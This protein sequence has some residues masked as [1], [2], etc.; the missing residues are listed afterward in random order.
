MS[1]QWVFIEPN[2]VWM[3]RDS[4]PFDAQQNF[5]ARSVFPPYPM[6]IQGVIRTYFLES[7]GADWQRF[8]EGKERAE[9]HAIAGYSD[10]SGSM[11]IEGP[12]VARMVKGKPERLYPAPLDLLYNQKDYLLLQPAALPAGVVLDQP[13]AGWKPLLADATQENYKEAGG[14]LSE[15]QMG[16]YLQGKKPTGAP[17][18]D[19]YETEERVGLKLNAKRRAAEQGYLY[20]AQFLR[21]Y[22]GVG[23]LVG[24]SEK[25]FADRGV[26]GIGGE[27]RSGRYSMVTYQQRANAGKGRIK[28][29]LQ[30][31]AYFAQGWQPAGGDWSPFISGRL[32]SAAIGKPISISGWNI[33][34]R[35]PKALRHYVPAGSVF[36]FE[37]A[38]L[39]GL[40]FTET[41]AAEPGLNFG[42][43]GFGA[44]VS[45]TW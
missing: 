28:V 8:A 34:R 19:L 32:V 23:L 15:E 41:P 10:R 3:F 25:I 2:D 4:R 37:D 27:A 30:T 22:D 24:V 5:V 36:Y 7:R 6:T 12:F 35:E 44:F 21:L 38:Q 11:E 29:I 14:W 17:I 45:T 1:K 20:H 42:S 31:P 39:T 33:A 13:V 43:M 16:A 40:P 18:R 9:L 26:I